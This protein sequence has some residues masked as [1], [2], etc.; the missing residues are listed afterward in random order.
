MAYAD[1]IEGGSPM[2]AASVAPTLGVDTVDFETVMF[3]RRSDGIKVTVEGMS[4]ATGIDLMV[5]E[6]GARITV[7]PVGC[8]AEGHLREYSLVTTLEPSPDRRVVICGLHQSESVLIS[9][10][11]ENL[12]VVCSPDPLRAPVSGDFLHRRG[13]R[14]VLMSSDDQMSSIERGRRTLVA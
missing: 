9:D 13:N 1:Q 5:F 12:P 2:D 4:C 11:P 14:Y 8:S 6:S 10:L 7:T 3:E